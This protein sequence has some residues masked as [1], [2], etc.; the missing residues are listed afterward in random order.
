M[1]NCI[2]SF[3][4]SGHGFSGV[5]CQ[6]GEITVATSLERITREKNDILLP[7]TKV[8]LETFGWT[9]DPK[10]YQEHLDLPFDFQGD[11]SNV[12]F[13]RLEKFQ[14]LLNYL[15]DAGGITLDDVNCVVYSYRYN[16]SARKFFKERNPRIE[17]IVPEHHFS[18]ACQAFLPSP[19]KE[20]AIMVVDG[21]GVPLARTGGD[22]LSGCLA[23]GKGNSVGILKDLPVRHSLGGMYSA[24][25]KAVGF[26]TSEEGK[27]MGLAPYGK[28]T[29]YEVLKNDLKFNAFDFDIR[30]PLKMLKRGFIP[31][32]VL[33]KLPA[34]GRFLRQFKLR[35]K[36]E[37]LT[38]L[39]KD[40]AYAV[41]KLTEDVMVFLADWLYE[42]T[43]SKNLCIA[44]GVG[45]NCVA[46]YQVFARSKFENI[47]IHPNSGD[48]GLA[49]GQALHVYNQLQGNNRKYVATT[50]SLGK[51]YSDSEIKKAV[52][53]HKSNDSISVTEFEDL[54]HL[55]DL[56]ASHIEAGRITSWFQ[57]RSE[58]G[59]RALGN[60]SI[61]ADP[62][63]PD[64]KDIL[65]SR[66]KFRE[67][68]RPFTPSVLA[69]RCSDFFEL[70]IDAPFMLLAAYVK[71]GKGALVPA[72]THVDNTA[73]V[74]TVTRKVN[75]PYYDLI[76]A[77]ERRTGIPMVLET[78][79]NVAGEPIVETPEDAIRC[80]LSTDIDVL[81]IDR[82]FL[83]KLK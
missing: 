36:G 58:F 77:F 57:G 67:S 12:D 27:T 5:V 28:G 76:K 81:C 39:H 37:E 42:K 19:F 34:Y 64:M 71:P 38:D 20:A 78:S 48:N 45:L 60:R 7:I 52:E 61:I 1:K 22:Q 11:Y 4:L 13:G 44:G 66:V 73:R 50:D 16:E 31:E 33:Y 3:T 70:D 6:D 14:L 47:F 55:Y 35:Q 54:D 21:Q 53:A 65:N 51:L 41:Q 9:S 32:N 18:H 15:L 24:F 8:D 72:I 74:Q 46:N 59:P 10:V 80:F 79:F 43:G 26:D 62:R 17:F 40:L 83:S 25:T 68:F 49:V 63:R 56:M 23:Y 75:A 29:F 82:F 69:E 30:N 2:L